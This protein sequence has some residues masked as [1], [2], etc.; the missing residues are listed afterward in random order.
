MEYLASYQ[1][2]QGCLF[3]A[4]G[5][6]PRF[7][8]SNLVASHDILQMVL[9]WCFLLHLQIAEDEHVLTNI[10]QIGWNKPAIIPDVGL[11]LQM[12]TLRLRFV[13]FLV[14]IPLPETNSKSTWK[15]IVV[16][17]FLGPGLF[18]G[19]NLLVSW[20]VRPWGS[21]EPSF[22]LKSQWKRDGLVYLLS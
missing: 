4:G 11:L 13:R 3:E 2:L 21:F 20:G 19:V 14:R 22:W 18:S 17:S 5:T 9:F 8:K 12:L 7:F 6:S 16:Q 10:V 1:L 15:W